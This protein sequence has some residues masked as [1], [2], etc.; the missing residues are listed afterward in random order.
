MEE[1]MGTTVSFNNVGFFGYLLVFDCFM[2][3]LLLA[4]LSGEGRGR[5]HD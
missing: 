3:E 5:L 2:L 1:M 4:G